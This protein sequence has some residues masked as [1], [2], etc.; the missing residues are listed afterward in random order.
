MYSTGKENTYLT[1]FA[2]GKWILNAIL[3]AI[4]LCL[5]FYYALEPSFMEYGLYEM[6]T[7]VFTA[8]CL[9]L[10][11]KVAYLHHQWT[12]PQ[13]LVMAISV[14]GMFLYFA[15]VSSSTTDYYGVTDWLFAKSLYWLFGFFFVPLICM[16]MDFI[17][18]NLNMFFF[19]TKEMHYREIE[20]KVITLAVL[21]SAFI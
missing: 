1:T 20:H 7:T 14:C 17:G 9:S 4:V 5:M 15:I 11:C 19:P 3:Y 21:L 2:I 16:L 10:Q 18:Y 6:G 12:W 13:C 8:L